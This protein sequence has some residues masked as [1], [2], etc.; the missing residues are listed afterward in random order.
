[1]TQDTTQF[2]AK[3]L[4]LMLA[5]VVGA[6]ILTLCIAI[7]VFGDGEAQHII[8]DL[9]PVALGAV[10]SIATAFIGHSVAGAIVS[11]KSGGSASATPAPATPATPAQVTISTAHQ[12]AGQ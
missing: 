12:M 4:V 11:L 6:I 7:F 10:S 8:S 9:T 1:M 2:V 3:V 5:G